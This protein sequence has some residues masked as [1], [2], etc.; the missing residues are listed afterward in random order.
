MKQYSKNLFVLAALLFTKGFG[1]PRLVL[2]ALGAFAAMCLLSSATYVVND[3]VDAERDRAHPRKRLRPVASGAVSVPAAQGVAVGCLVAGLA[4]ALAVGPETLGCGVAYLA[5][6]VAYNLGL[7]RAPIADVFTIAAGFVLRVVVGAVAIQAQ[8]SG[9]ILLCTGAL[10]LLLGFGKRR[11]EF[12]AQGEARGA[13]RE[14]LEGYT[15]PALD[16]LVVLSAAATAIAYGLYGIGSA[17]ARANPGLILTVPFVAFGV[18]RYMALIFAGTE[19]AEPESL[20]FR[21]RAMLVSLALFVV[22]AVAALTGL[23]VGFLN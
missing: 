21:D 11:S 23:R 12:V 10:A 14:S 6:Q 13:T 5:I 2:L 4:L 15:L 17:T 9:W 19:S 20:V 22:T 8:V 7:K 18:C 1:E 3:I 16:G